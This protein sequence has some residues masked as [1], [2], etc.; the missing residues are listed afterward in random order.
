MHEVEVYMYVCIFCSA[1]SSKYTY[2]FCVIY[3]R[4]IQI[5]ADAWENIFE[6]LEC[7]QYI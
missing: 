4:I 2:Y 3:S 5:G 1:G 7:L 6:E